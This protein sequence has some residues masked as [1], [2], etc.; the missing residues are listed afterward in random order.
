M[1]RKPD[2]Q[3]IRFYT[4]GSAARQLQADPCRKMK[5]TVPK[6]SRPQKQ[7]KTLFVDPLAWA[8]IA[9]SAVMLVL[10]LVGG[11]K[12]FALY[13]QAESMES[14]ASMLY[15]QNVELKSDYESG[16]DLEQIE[17]VAHA[18]GLVPVEE[19]TITV[20]L[21]VRNTLQEK[22]DMWGTLSL[23]FRGLFA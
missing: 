17:G 2:I 6:A 9:I 19:K 13:Q 18:L 16:Y 23:F 3:Y 4:D 11:V 12:L 22:P 21:P 20:S 5:Y 15:A 7:V 10:M 14:Y 8:G 1:S